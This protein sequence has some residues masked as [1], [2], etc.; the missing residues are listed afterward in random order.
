VIAAFTVILGQIPT[1]QIS[2]LQQPNLH[3]ICA[4]K[5]P[6]SKY[7]SYPEKGWQK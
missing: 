4:Q 1:L 2:L 5:C 6:E 3:S 7:D